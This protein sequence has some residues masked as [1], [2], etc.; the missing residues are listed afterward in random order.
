MPAPRKP[1]KQPET[2]PVDEVIQMIRECKLNQFRKV[3]ED[4]RKRDHHAYNFVVGLY[5]SAKL[6]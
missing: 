2:L 1:D 5:R 4:L 6:Q 3:L